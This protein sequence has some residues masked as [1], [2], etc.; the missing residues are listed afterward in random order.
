MAARV[1]G[2]PSPFPAIASRSSSSSTNLPA[3]SIAESKVASVY[4][5]GAF[6]AFSS[7]V[8]CSTNTCSFSETAGKVA[9]ASTSRPYTASQPALTRIFPSVFSFS[10]LTVVIRVVTSYSAAGKKTAKKRLTTKS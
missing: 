1:A 10:F 3:P 2:V 7:T 6:V 4:R 8:D 9:S 5:G